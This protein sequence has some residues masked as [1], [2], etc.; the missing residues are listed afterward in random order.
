MNFQ[1][2]VQSTCTTWILTVV[3]LKGQS[4]SCPF[5]TVLQPYRLMFLPLSQIAFLKRMLKTY[6]LYKQKFNK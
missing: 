6:S 1:V 5:H 4:G 2:R 3:D